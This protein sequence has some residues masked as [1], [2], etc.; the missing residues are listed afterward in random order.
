MGGGGCSRV[1]AGNVLTSEWG[2]R[3]SPRLGSVR[4]GSGSGDMGLLG[5]LWPLPGALGLTAGVRP[6]TGGVRPR[7]LGA[8]LQRSGLRAGQ[9]ELEASSRLHGIS[10]SSSPRATKGAQIRALPLGTG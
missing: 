8:G 2:P 3:S 4:G 6:P 9:R 5:R 7:L 1:L 10:G